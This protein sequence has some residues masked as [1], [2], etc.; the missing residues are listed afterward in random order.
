[1]GKLFHPDSPAIQFLWKMA[2]LIALN[3]ICLVCCIPVVT[4]GPSVTAMYCVA[5]KI[6]RGEWPSI[7]KTFFK[8]F[9]VNFKQAFIVWLVLLIPILLVILYLVLSFSGSLDSLPLIKYMCYLAIAII[10]V[11]WTYVHPLM[12]HFENTTGNVLKNALLLPFANPVIAVAATLLNLLPLLLMVINFELF[13]AI[14]FLWLVIGFSLTALVNTKMLGLL[15]Q[16][17]V[18]E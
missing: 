12:A 18:Q 6:A 2:D 8:E 7:L 3:I 15:F 10:G 1:M 17:L 14:S 5:R 9:K 4:I 11:V 16:K 13:A